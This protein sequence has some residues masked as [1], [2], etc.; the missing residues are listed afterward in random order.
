LIIGA[1]PFLAAIVITELLGTFKILSPKIV[2][3]YTLIELVAMLVVG[4]GWIILYIRQVKSKF[5]RG[6]ST[7]DTM[8][9][10]KLRRNFFEWPEVRYAVFGNKTNRLELFMGSGLKRRTIWV[11]CHDKETAELQSF[12]SEKLGDRLK[13]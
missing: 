12:L 9:G 10:T 7:L 11:R 6:E 3:P 8:L 4:S 13:G 1:A 2:I 5:P